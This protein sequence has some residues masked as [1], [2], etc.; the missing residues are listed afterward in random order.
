MSWG[1]RPPGSFYLFIHS[2]EVSAM[3]V[4]SYLFI[5]PGKA[6]QRHH[7]QPSSDYKLVLRWG[8]YSSALSAHSTIRDNSKVSHDVLVWFVV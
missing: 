7:P 8:L 6:F 4:K 2:P 1:E 5:Q 3:R